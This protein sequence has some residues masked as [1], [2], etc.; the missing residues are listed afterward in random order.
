MLLVIQTDQ[1]RRVTDWRV[2]RDP[3]KFD[4]QEITT[5][6]R[7]WSAV[8]LFD[9]KNIMRLIAIVAILMYITRTRSL[10]QHELAGI[11]DVVR[12][13]NI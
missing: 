5:A 8:G 10:Y 7:R 4:A 2:I 12:S 3:D 11:F 13:L 6:F 1:A 9:N